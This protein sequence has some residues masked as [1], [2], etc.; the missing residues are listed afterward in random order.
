M[1]TLLLIAAAAAP[2]A[3]PMAADDWQKMKIVSVGQTAEGPYYL[4]VQAGDLDDDGAPDDAYLKLV[5]TGGKLQQ[6]MYEVKPR[7]AGSGIAT[8]K[9]MHKPMVVV[10]GWDPVSKRLAAVGTGYDLKNGTKGR[11]AA[12]ADGWTPLSLSSG[13]ETCAALAAQR[14]TIVKSKSNISNN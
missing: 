1:W 2:D 14:S 4:D 9:R 5:C 10:R 12:G 7:D 3:K 6:A 13:D 8:G 11:M